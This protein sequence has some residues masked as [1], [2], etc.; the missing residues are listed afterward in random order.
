MMVSATSS[1]H[2]I[3]ANRQVAL[4]TLAVLCATVFSILQM[5]STRF[6]MGRPMSFVPQANMVPIHKLVMASRFFYF[7]CNWS[8]KHSLLLFYTK[9][10]I[11][12][13]PRRSIYFMHAIAFAFGCTCIGA[14]LFQCIPI[15]AMWNTNV[16]GR[17][18]DLNAF[19][20]FN[21]CFMLATDL[22]LYAM[23]LIFT[24]NLKLRRPQ[25]I[26]V[27]VLFALG[28]F[29]LAASGARVYCVHAQAMDPDLTY[30]FAATM[31]CAVIENHLAIIVACAPN[32]KVA[33]LLVFPKLASKLEKLI[34]RKSQRDK[35]NG[36]SGIAIGLEAA[37]PLEESSKEAIRPIT[38]RAYTDESKRSRESRESR[39]SRMGKRWR[40][41]SSWDVSAVERIPHA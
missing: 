18:I 41:P 35:D 28:I 39:E 27:N 31:I 23:P 5:I 19:N 17:C 26:G 20:Y 3:K 25:K 2:N 36:S 4:I 21:S 6:G 29:V 22:V 7:I 34:S 1:E 13:W 24:W 14:T 30:N 32:M 37:F 11:D 12:R 16:L 8:V 40:A 10:T 9:L 38:T 33:L 15:Q